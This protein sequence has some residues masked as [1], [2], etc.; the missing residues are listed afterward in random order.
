ME[1]HLLQ[2]LCIIAPLLFI[3]N[4]TSLWYTSESSNASLRPL[5]KN[6]DFHIELNL[7]HVL[8]STKRALISFHY[9]TLI[10]KYIYYSRKDFHYKMT[11]IS[12]EH[13]ISL[14][15]EL[16]SVRMITTKHLGKI[17]NGEE[18]L[19]KYTNL[20]M[21]RRKLIVDAHLISYVHLPCIEWFLY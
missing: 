17:G 1:I 3:T 14:K 15:S 5:K 18:T 2:V 4:T 7:A 13:C 9:T 21:K 10:S 16:P 20:K 11:Q 19:H 8:P 6:C 12:L